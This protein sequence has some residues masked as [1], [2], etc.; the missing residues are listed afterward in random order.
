MKLFKCFC[1][2]SLSVFR[3]LSVQ[4]QKACLL[5]Y[6]GCCKFIHGPI[7]ESSDPSFVNKAVISL[8]SS[9]VSMLITKHTNVCIQTCQLTQHLKTNCITHTHNNSHADP[10][11]NHEEKEEPKLVE[12]C[13]VHIIHS[14]LPEHLHVSKDKSKL[15][16]N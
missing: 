6:L 14:R 13:N 5:N 16:F 11:E 7:N 10:A 1:S 9:S 8:P 3:V 4:G 12:I 15:H 2:Y